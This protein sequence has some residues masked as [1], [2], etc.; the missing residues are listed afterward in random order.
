MASDR[1]RAVP[2]LVLY[3]YRD[4]TYRPYCQLCAWMGE[5]TTDA[6]VA[7]G[8][9]ENHLTSDEHRGLD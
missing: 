5:V 7:Q 1:K 9:L 4:M 6:Q 2:W 8:W 3:D